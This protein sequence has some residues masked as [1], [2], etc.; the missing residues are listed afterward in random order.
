M[1]RSSR[2]PVAL[3]YRVG[4]YL[5]REICCESP[6]AAGGNRSADIEGLLMRKAGTD[7]VDDGQSAAH[8]RRNGAEHGTDHNYLDHSA[9][10]FSSKVADSLHIE[11]VAQSCR[12]RAC[13]G[14]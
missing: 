11:L 10:A 5:C 14:P 13:R 3:P 2:L 1:S 4:G 12:C 9:V 7:V 6:R 8:C